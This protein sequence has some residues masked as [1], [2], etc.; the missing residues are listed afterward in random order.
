MPVTPIQRVTYCTSHD[1]EKEDEQRL[2]PFLQMKN[3]SDGQAIRQIGSVFA[4]M[5]TSVGIPMFLGGEEF[6]ELQDVEHSNW[7]E[8][9][10][11]GI[12][13]RRADLPGRDVLRKQ[14]TELIKLRTSH[15]ALHRNEVDFFYVHPRFDDNNEARVF[16]YCRTGGMNLGSPGQIIIVANCGQSYASFK[17]NGWSW[18]S[19]TLTEYGGTKQSLPK[20]NGNEAELELLAYQVRVFSV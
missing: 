10:S 6:A 1:I 14:I 8:K 7:R 15:P 11:S 16:A 19:Q 13:W 17:I 20:I 5:L 12:D 3:S 18:G 2:F 4:L 9:M